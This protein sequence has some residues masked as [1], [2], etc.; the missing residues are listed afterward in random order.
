MLFIVNF[1]SLPT[2][3]TKY[4][5]YLIVYYLL[6]IQALTVR[7]IL[8]PNAADALLSK[9]IITDFR[10]YFRHAKLNLIM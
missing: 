1:Q 3:Y 4:S 9:N 7:S 2:P 8:G 6:A 5:I 10:N